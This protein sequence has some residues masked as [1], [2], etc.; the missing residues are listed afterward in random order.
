MEPN[1]ERLEEFQELLNHPGWQTYLDLI[2]DEMLSAFQQIFYLDASK[3][4]SFIKFVELKG[5]IDQLRNI[6]YDYER[7]MAV[8]PEVVET[9][10]EHY[11]SIFK[12]L[13][14]KLFQR[15]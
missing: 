4:E 9:V 1:Q 10:D 11:T 3:P 6:T 8:N 15:S 5:R 12:R 2:S 14:D 7:Q 13:M